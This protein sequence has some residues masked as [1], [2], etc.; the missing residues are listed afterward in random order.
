[1]SDL[2]TTATSY[3]VRDLFQRAFNIYGPRIAV[4]AEEGQWTYAE[5]GEQARRLAAALHGLGLRQ[6]ERVAVLSETRPEYVVTYAALAQ[7]GITVL[8]LN[9]RLHPDELRYCVETGKPAALLASG[10]LTHLVAGLPGAGTSVRSWICFDGT[11]DGFESY[12]DLLAAAGGETAAAA[13]VQATDIHN[14]LY[15]SGTT[16]RPKGAMIS[17]GAA[18]IRGLRLAQWFGLTPDDGFIG[19]LPLFHCGGDESLYATMLT[20]GTFGALR[21]ADVETMFRMIERDRLSWTLLLP[22]VITDFLHHPRRADYDLATFRFAIG[23]ANMMPNVIQQLTAACG[24]DFY[25]AFGQTESSY[26][27]A[28]GVS[29]PGEQP[30]LRKLPSPLLDVRIVADDLTELPPGRPG[31]CV[32][33]G[34]SVMSGY[35]DDPAATE[36]A[37]RGGWLHTGDLLT[38]HEDGTLSFVDRKKYLIKT[39]GENVYPAEVEQVIAA[40]PAVQEV[41]VFGVPDERWGETVKAA[42]V[43]HPG[44]EL[45]AAG[46][47][48]WCRDRLAGYK[49]PRYLVFLAPGELPRS[50]TGKVQRHEL[51]KLPARPEERV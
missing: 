38:R 14:V 18:A 49:R 28:H 17:H 29:H 4:T 15:T 40:H 12:P 8:T 26:L 25:D 21:K 37:F 34:P 23:Y 32:V 19:W 39:G 35:L 5:I 31:E 1:M 48:A 47:G 43:L 9:I 42:V 7:L 30:S 51:A 36:A 2:A 20:G 22:G 46:L 41:C 45:T 16:G 44:A 10:L 50:T 33:R 27:L 24:I 3:T 11:Q 6:G 13:D